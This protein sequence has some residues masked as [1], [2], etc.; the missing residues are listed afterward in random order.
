MGISQV[1]VRTA[2]SQAPPQTTELEPACEE[3][4]PVICMT[5]NFEKYCTRFFHLDFPLT[6][7][8]HKPF[9]SN[10]FN[11]PLPACLQFT[12]SPEITIL[13]TGSTKPVS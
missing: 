1:L 4:S 12:L 2:E 3:D 8:T 9:P 10:I 13:I 7:H 5:L 11:I 6:L